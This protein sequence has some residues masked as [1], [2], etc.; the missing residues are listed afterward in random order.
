MKRTGENRRDWTA[1]PRIRTVENVAVEKA[2]EKERQRERERG[3]GLVTYCKLLVLF[4]TDC[5]TLPQSA[6]ARCSVSSRRS[7][8]V[9][10][11]EVFSKQR[12]T[13]GLISALDYGLLGSV[14]TVLSQPFISCSFVVCWGDIWRFF[15]RFHFH[16]RLWPLEWSL[17]VIWELFVSFPSPPTYWGGF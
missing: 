5:D 2:R 1:K 17:T 12:V 10:H 6:E 3:A 13:K 11:P 7:A 4:G 16:C 14:L 15:V 8:L 9:P